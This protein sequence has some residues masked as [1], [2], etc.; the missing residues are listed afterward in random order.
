MKN[1]LNIKSLTFGAVLGAIVVLSV[2]QAKEHSDQSSQ[3]KLYDY[4][5]LQTTIPGDLEQRLKQLG[6]DGWL[7]VSSTSPD[8]AA[9]VVLV[10]LKRD[11]VS[12]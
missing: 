12:N 7:A 2:G 5:V 1:K 8:G 3:S 9:G 4:K 6:D 11:K 10:I